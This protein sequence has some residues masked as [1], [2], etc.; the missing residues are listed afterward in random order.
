[1]SGSNTFDSNNIGL[2]GNQ[3]TISSSSSSSNK[4]FGNGAIDTVNTDPWKQH[5][6]SRNPSSHSPISLTSPSAIGLNFS[7][8]SFDD[9]SPSSISNDTKT[10]THEVEKHT[11]DSPF[12]NM[13]NAKSLLESSSPSSFLDDDAILNDDSLSTS[14]KKNLLQKLL[15]LSASNG[16]IDSVRQILG[17]PAMAFIDINGKDTNTGS[18]ALIYASCFGYE[19]VVVELLRYGAAINIQD[20]SKYKIKPNFFY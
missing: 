11:P 15:F 5:S 18:T 19:E 10:N 12:D 17:G 20:K 7:D 16:N 8:R 4:L 3:N 9:D 2:L 1:M 6:H 13:I 14:E